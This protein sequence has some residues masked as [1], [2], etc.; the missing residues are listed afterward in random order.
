MRIVSGL[1]IPHPYNINLFS[2]LYILL[3]RFRKVGNSFN[4]EVL[5]MSKKSSQMKR[6]INGEN[7]WWEI[8]QNSEQ[9]LNTQLLENEHYYL[10]PK[11]SCLFANGK[12]WRRNRKTNRQVKAVL[13]LCKKMSFRLQRLLVCPTAKRKYDSFTL[14][15]LKFPQ[16]FFIQNTNPWHR[17]FDITL[18]PCGIAM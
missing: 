7:C 3:R 4:V 2:H 18:L 6:K 10:Y 17:F 5:H 13:V 12:K 1:V 8:I 11:V 9:F 16:N 14:V 15:H